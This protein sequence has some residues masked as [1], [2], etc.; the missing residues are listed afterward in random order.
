MVLIE[1]RSC[2]QKCGDILYPR[3][4]MYHDIVGDRT[5]ASRLAV[6]AEAFATQLS[7]LYS[8]GFETLTASSL[9]AA[10]TEGVQLPERAV[11]ITYDDGFA[12]L[13]EIVLPLL[14]RY[15]FTATVYITTEWIQDFRSP[16]VVRRPGKMLCWGQIREL[17]DAGIEIGAHSC[18]HPQLDQL[19]A[20]HLEDE[21]RISK[22][23]LEDKLHRSV[24]GMA[25]PF[26]YSNMVVRKGARLAGYRYACIVGNRLIGEPWDPFA[27]PRL[28]IKR[29]TR[30]GDFQRLAYGQNLNRVFLVD[31][32]LTSCW[33][34]VRYSRRMLR[35]GGS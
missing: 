23:T 19:P 18:S 14:D 9:V 31:H 26:G 30:L 15:K 28:T 21:L 12:D 32:T 3:I 11:V 24:V 17:A 2:N 29:S 5:R 33:A 16:D 25:Y 13:H 7:Y 22:L 4:L 20:G 6:P 10:L 1:N 8:E 34:S 27:L 35:R